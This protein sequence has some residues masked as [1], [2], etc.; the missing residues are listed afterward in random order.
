MKLL[1]LSFI[2]LLFSSTVFSLDSHRELELPKPDFNLIIEMDVRPLKE[3]RNKRKSIYGESSGFSPKKRSRRSFCLDTPKKELLGVSATL[4]CVYKRKKLFEEDSSGLPCQIINSYESD[5][6]SGLWA[7]VDPAAPKSS[8]A[9]D[10][11]A[12]DW[13]KF[14][15]DVIADIDFSSQERFIA[16]TIWA[17]HEKLETVRKIMVFQ[18]GDELVCRH[19]ATLALP[20]FTKLLM[21][22]ENSFVGKIHQISADIYKSGWSHAG[23]GHVWNFLSIS[24]G[25]EESHW[26]VD[27]FRKRFINLSESP[28]LK[29]L[30]EKRVT[31]EGG[32]LSNNLN[33]KSDFYDYARLTKEKFGIS[34]RA[35]NHIGENPEA[36][37][38]V[39]NKV[40]A[41]APLPEACSVISPRKIND[42]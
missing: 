42:K 35:K 21:H 40:L 20:I 10:C 33:Q 2:I 30:S 41:R 23:D 24:E 6:N 31:R 14:I 28:F 12:P 26:L 17:I 9:I 1:E 4:K 34:P 32:I 16:S 22:S 27:V 37:K 18:K 13:D 11:D 5:F 38:L 3:I 29:R 15:E 39:L 19:F 7:Y 25:N 36:Q 8:A